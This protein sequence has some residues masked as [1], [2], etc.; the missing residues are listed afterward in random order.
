MLRLRRYVR[1]SFPPAVYL[2]YALAW[3]LGGTA[4]FALG[5]H[6][7]HGQR[8]PR[9]VDGVGTWQPGWATLATVASFT[10]LLLMVR[11][12]DDL[13]DLDYDRVHN[14]RRPLASGA[15]AVGDV[16][17]LIGA[18]TVVVLLLNAPRGL[19]LTGAAT[20]LLYLA[21]LLAA[22]RLAHWPSGD[23]LIV[24]ALISLPVQ[25][26]LGGYLYATL[27]HDS[28]QS[29]GPAA[30]LPLAAM[31]AV[32]THLELARKTT[33]APKPGER[34]YTTVFGVEATARAA[35]GA[36]AVATVLAL[37]LTQPWNP[38]A[39]AG[40]LVLLPAALPVRGALRFWRGGAERWPSADAGFYVL[41]AF[42]AFLVVDLVERHTP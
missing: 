40:W 32:F 19:A 7:K 39:Q 14:P 31:L 4:M 36:A 1:G 18:G 2:P 16:G 22:D 33:R 21:V 37:M 41:A 11:A 20:A 38:G 42:T 5:Q 30:L 26:L 10:V 27:L 3:A 15:V 35:L 29:A 6:G 17:L 12:V 28:H 13:R 9:G 23:A 8:G 24:S 34:A 25:L